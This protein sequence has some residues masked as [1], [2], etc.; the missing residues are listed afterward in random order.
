MRISIAA[1]VL[2]A[3]ACATHWHTSRADRPLART[4]L[5]IHPVTVDPAPEPLRDAVVQTLKDKGFRVVDHPPYRGD[6]KLV[7]AVN[8]DRA[9][10]TLRSDD[11][12]VDEAETE[13]LDPE[14]AAAA[15]VD[16]LAVSEGLA[17]YMR[18]NGTPAQQMIPDRGTWQR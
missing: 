15:L 12:F 5:G 14:K 11:F 10:A 4:E 17:F 2:C 8:G 7:L 3:M 9:V 1:S 16:S 6:L 18:F 13:L